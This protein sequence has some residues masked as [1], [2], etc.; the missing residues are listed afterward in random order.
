[1]RCRIVHE[2]ADKLVYEIRQI[3]ILARKIEKAGVAMTW[4]N[5]G[6]PV[7]K[8]EHVPVWIIE[9]LTDV[10]R[11]NRSWG[12]SPSK[13][14]D[15]TRDYLSL[16][17]NARRKA[18]ITPEDIYFYNGLGDAVSKL[19]GYLNRGARVLCPS[20]SYSIH[21]THE[22]FH[23]AGLPPLLYHLDPVNG[24]LPDPD[25]IRTLVARNK[26]VAGILLIN[27]DNPTGVVWPEELVRKV[28]AI[29]AE[30]GLFV[31]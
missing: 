16:R 27:P 2:Q 28:V 9:H 21:A 8:N 23:A 18:K 10:A 26:E 24:W 7:V 17:H 3:V 30:Y 31:I 5:I 14:M 1:M 13:G 6:D 15:A 11:K 20:P 19:Y 22:S 29:A 4:E 12:Y 25:E